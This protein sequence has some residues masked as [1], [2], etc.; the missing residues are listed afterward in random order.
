MELPEQPVAT[1]FTR[2]RVWA[3]PA[4]ALL[5]M[6]ILLLNDSNQAVFLALNHAA[7][8]LPPGLWASL[9]AVGDTLVAFALLLPFVRRRPD[10]AAAILLATLFALVYVHSLKYALDL[11]RPPAVLDP[12]A[13]D[14]IGPAHRAGSFPSG[15][16]ATAFA[17]MALLSVYLPS[18]RRLLP[19]IALAA[20]VGLSRIAVG[21]HWPL[22]VLAGAAGGWLA[23]L[24]GIVL[25]Q[26]W[27]ALHHPWLH[28]AV[29]ALLIAGAAWLMI[30][31]DSGYPQAQ[32]FEQAIAFAG[33]ALFFRP[34]PNGT[35]HD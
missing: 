2:S 15:H 7:A 20:L 12:A 5:A 32:R 25:A 30:G 13:F 9:T 21:V 29:Q 1:A 4:V 6:A 24:A 35:N 3:L 14:V 31:H 17:M 19:L 23:G 34:M 26:R 11:P 18:W 8:A 27:Q 22:D 10:L 28:G 16:T 33:L